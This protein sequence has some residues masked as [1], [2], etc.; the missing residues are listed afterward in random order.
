MFENV[1][2]GLNARSEVYLSKEYFCEMYATYVSFKRFQ[3][4]QNTPYSLFHDY[5]MLPKALQNHY[6]RKNIRTFYLKTNF[7]IDF[8]EYH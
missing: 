2:K 7:V 8:L 6:I 5:F 4:I 1:H 3:F